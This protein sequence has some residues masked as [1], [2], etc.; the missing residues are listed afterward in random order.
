MLY[1][2]STSGSSQYCYMFVRF[3]IYGLYSS[4][5]H[6]HHMSPRSKAVTFSTIP[7]PPWKFTRLQI[8]QMI[9]RL[10]RKFQRVAY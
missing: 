3:W 2:I 8:T 1:N 4:T 5:V 6:S 9:N 10:L 7:R